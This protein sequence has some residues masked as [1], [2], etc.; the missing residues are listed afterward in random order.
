MKRVFII[1]GWGGHPDYHWQPWLKQELERKGFSVI[2]PQMPDTGHPKVDAWVSFLAKTV[3]KPDNDTYFIG[4]SMGCKA[5][6]LYLQ[7][8]NVQVGGAV[9]VAGF[10]SSIQEEKMKIEEN[11]LVL[12]PWL[13]APVDAAKARRN[14]KSIVGIFSDNDQWIPLD[15]AQVYKA[16]LG[17]RIVI[18]KGKG[19]FGSRDNPIKELPIV[20]EELL[21]IT[22]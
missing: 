15:T 6:L 7:S 2:T 11:R 13:A 3:G 16:E 14:A 12:G 10:W 9:L 18:E 20:L 1:H 22:R 21:K 8:I 5:I 19:H 17:A 4:H